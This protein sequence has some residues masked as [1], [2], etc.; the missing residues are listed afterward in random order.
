MFKKKT[1][2]APDEKYAPGEEGAEK[3]GDES[4]SESGS[5]SSGSSWGSSEEW[6]GEEEWE[7]GEWDSG[8]EWS[9]E[10]ETETGSD[11]E[12]DNL[13]GVLDIDVEGEGCASFRA[14]PWVS[15]RCAPLTRAG[16]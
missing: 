8:E 14:P 1:K 2:V 9:S 12:V 3:G 16:T 4:G 5:Y 13:C 6:S 15:A 10:W 7:E 11:S